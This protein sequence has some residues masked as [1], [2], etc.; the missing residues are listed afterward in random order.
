MSGRFSLMIV[1]YVEKLTVHSLKLFR[2]QVIKLGE[3]F[4]TGV[5]H[6]FLHKLL[7]CFNN[8]KLVISL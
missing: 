8:L 7:I 5:M 6:L 2:S 1:I 3:C 4:G